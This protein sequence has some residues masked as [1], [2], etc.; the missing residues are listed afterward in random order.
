MMIL[1]LT[2]GL[3]AILSCGTAFVLNR[4]AITIESL[5]KIVT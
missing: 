3:W 5:D 1:C 2:T 4:V